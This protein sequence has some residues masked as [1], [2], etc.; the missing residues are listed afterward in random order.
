MLWAE[1]LELA[2]LAKIIWDK[3]HMANLI[4][5]DALR[6]E[7]GFLSSEVGWNLC[8]VFLTRSPEILI[9][10]NPELGT[11]LLD[12]FRGKKSVF[13]ILPLPQTNS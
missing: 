11:P 8:S 13:D 10:R 7:Q 12:L 4:P 3:T 6:R 2:Q 5:G 9:Q 1:I